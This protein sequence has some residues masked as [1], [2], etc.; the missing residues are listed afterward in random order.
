MIV[1]SK[2]KTIILLYGKFHEILSRD[3]G[4]SIK[5]VTLFLT[6]FDPLPSLTLCHTSRTPHKV[7]HIPK[8]P[9][10][11]TRLQYALLNFVRNALISIES[12]LYCIVK[13][14]FIPLNVYKWTPNMC[15]YLAKTS[16]F[17]SICNN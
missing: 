11:I 13:K 9:P 17:Y 15:S 8:H 2:L 7:R 5:Y 16:K 14:L 12:Q 10:R 1:K 4:P 3:M 6:N